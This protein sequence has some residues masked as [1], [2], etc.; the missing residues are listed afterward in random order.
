M[1]R[2]DQIVAHLAVQAYA[3]ALAQT[4]QLARISI[5]MHAITVKDVL[6]QEYLLYHFV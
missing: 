3:E 1:K 2:L 6:I 4:Y 5:S